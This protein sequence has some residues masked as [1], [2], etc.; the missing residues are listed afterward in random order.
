M[1]LLRCP[2][3]KEP[4][5]RLEKRYCCT[6]GHSFDIARQGYVNLLQ[7]QRSSARTH[8][9]D[10]DMVVARTAFLEKGYYSPLR[11]AVIDA[12]YNY[13]GQ[14]PSVVVDAGCGEGWYTQGVAR[15]CPLAQVIGL[16]ISKDALKWAAKRPELHHLAVASCFDMPLADGCA[17]AVLNIL[18]PLAAAEYGRVLKPGG[19]L[20]RVVPDTYH[21]WELKETVYETPKPN[22]PEP[23]ELAGLSLLK[24]IPIHYQ[25]ELTSNQD[26]Q[27]LFQMTPYFYRT[28][29]GDRA[30][31]NGVDRLSTRAEFNLLIFQKP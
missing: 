26:I 4:L 19:V 8:G 5:A 28:S 17:D 27:V 14:K 6:K 30:K 21:L 2:V 10:R 29:P 15:K 16:D 9:D 22:R 25:M 7:S 18:S 31:L 12:V 1:D 23:E 13:T 3:C 11:D 20:V 24:K